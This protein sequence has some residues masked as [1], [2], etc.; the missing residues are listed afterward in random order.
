MRRETPRL[1]YCALPLIA[2]AIAGADQWFKA[3][4]VAH[5]APDEARALIPGVVGLTHAQN[6]GASFGMFGNVRWLLPGVSAAALL[7]IAYFIVR[8]RVTRPAGLVA[9]AMI[10]GGALGNL[11]DRVRLGYVTDMFEFLF[12]RFAI[13]NVADIFITSG[14]ALLCLFLLLQEKNTVDKGQGTVDS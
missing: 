7:I 9:L 2:G 6:P 10:F 12:F 14:S 5:L 4:V 3:W 1:V 8:R 13:F 11:I